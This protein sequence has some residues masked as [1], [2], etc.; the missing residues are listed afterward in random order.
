MVEDMIITKIGNAL[1]VHPWTVD[2]WAR[3]SNGAHEQ[4]AVTAETHP[5]QAH[6]Y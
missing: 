2:D 3:L 1:I 5:A 6:Q 4:Y